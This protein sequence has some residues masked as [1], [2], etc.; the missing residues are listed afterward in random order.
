VPAGHD[1]DTGAMA[2]GPGPSVA[3]LGDMT[4]TGTTLTGTES[5]RLQAAADDVEELQE[6]LELARRRRDELIVAAH[7]DAGMSYGSIATAT[8][9]SRARIIAIIGLLDPG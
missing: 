4:T 3:P 6:A 9:L 1:S 8:R 2:V 7:D 5:A